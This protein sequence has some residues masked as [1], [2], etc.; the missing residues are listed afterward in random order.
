[1][2]ARCFTRC[3]EAALGGAVEILRVL[4]D[5][6]LVATQGPTWIVAGRNI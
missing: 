6:R 3:D 2:V 5:T 4:S 1:M